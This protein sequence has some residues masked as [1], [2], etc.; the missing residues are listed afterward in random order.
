MLMFCGPVLWLKITVNISE[1]HLAVVNILIKR[2][3]TMAHVA[4]V[5]AL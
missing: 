5:F 3:N 4:I 2:A 1:R